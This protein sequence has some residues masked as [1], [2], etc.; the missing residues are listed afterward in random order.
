MISLSVLVT[1]NCFFLSST[2]FPEA[3]SLIVL[4]KRLSLLPQR[5]DRRSMKNHRAKATL[6]KVNLDEKAESYILDEGTR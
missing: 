1:F 2:S 6:Q 4:P 5:A 3:K